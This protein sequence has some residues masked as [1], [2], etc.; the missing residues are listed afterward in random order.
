MAPNPKRNLDYLLKLLKSE[1]SNGIIGGASLMNSGVLK[2]GSPKLSPMIL[3]PWFFSSLAFAAIASVAE[4]GKLL[5]LFDNMLK[6]DY[7]SI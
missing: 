1:H 5:I 3:I 7:D 4:A 2:S 6:L